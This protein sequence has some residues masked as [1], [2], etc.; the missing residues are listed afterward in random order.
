MGSQILAETTGWIISYMRLPCKKT[1]FDFF[2][3]KF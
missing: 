3:N 2:E 1:G